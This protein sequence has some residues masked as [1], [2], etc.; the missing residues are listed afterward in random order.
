MK[1]SIRENTSKSRVGKLYRTRLWHC[2]QELEKSWSIFEQTPPIVPNVYKCVNINT[3]IL[4]LFITATRSERD[5]YI[6]LW[7]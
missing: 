2:I 6:Y 7:L 1:N 5:N 3:A 4:N